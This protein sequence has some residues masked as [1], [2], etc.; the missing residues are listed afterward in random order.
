ISAL[1]SHD[2][3]ALP[4]L[5]HAESVRQKLIPRFVM[6]LSQDNVHDRTFGIAALMACH[7]VTDELI[8]AIGGQLNDAETSVR[9]EAA[10]ALGQIGPKAASQL[11]RLRSMAETERYWRARQAAR[12]AIGAIAPQ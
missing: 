12:D 6:M 5:A 8:T 9:I 3:K 1:E 11:E 2:Y 7:T 4:A 10:K